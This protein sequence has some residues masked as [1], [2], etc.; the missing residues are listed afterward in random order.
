MSRISLFFKIPRISGVILDNY[1]AMEVESLSPGIVEGDQLTFVPIL[2]YQE[3]LD[4][5]RYGK[6]ISLTNNGDFINAQAV[7]CDLASS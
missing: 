2:V 3:C 5:R 4:W 7:K 1:R 6:T